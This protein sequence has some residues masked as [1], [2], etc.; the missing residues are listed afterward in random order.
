[1]KAFASVIVG[2]VCL[3]SSPGFA[4]VFPIQTHQDATRLKL[5]LESLSPSLRGTSAQDDLPEGLPNVSETHV[6]FGSPQDAVDWAKSVSAQ[7]GAGLGAKR[8]EVLPLSDSR[9]PVLQAQVSELWRA[10]QSLFPKYTAGLNEPPV[11]LVDSDIMNAFVPKHILE[12][13]KVAHTVVVLTALLDKAGGAD[14]KDL[15]SGMFAHELAHSVFRHVLDTYQG[16]LN[17]YYKV[18]FEGLGFESIRD[19]RLDSLLQTWTSGSSMAGDITAGELYNLP[20]EGVGRPLMRRVWNEMVNG[21][22]S[23]QDCWEAKDT[24][25]VWTSYLRTSDFASAVVLLPSDRSALALASESLIKSTDACLGSTRVPFLGLLSRVTGV[26]ES[27]LTQMPAFVELNE[28]FVN[29]P[30]PSQGLQAIIEP[31][32]ESMV[33]V[34]SKVSLDSLGYFTYEEHADDIS[35]IVHKFLGWNTQSLSDF[36]KIVMTP[37]DLAR[38][39]SLMT[40]GVVPPAGAFS[41]PHRA[42]C[43]RIDHLYRLEAR[44]RG[45]D[46][47]KFASDY[48]KSSIDY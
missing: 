14:R 7:L 6:L 20:S 5:A 47:Q 35:L 10:M 12:P 37:E 36:F 3:F 24:N 44:M 39:E 4:S 46:V 17:K 31:I 26:P 8:F 13:S 9:Y 42:V 48:V 16:R 28:S 23:S 27:V 21:F 22:A 2:L 33:D 32:R 34:E 40:A 25:K 41:D 18:G 30:T 45:Q 15:L 19:P 38:C 43:Y 1:M 29:A 11:V